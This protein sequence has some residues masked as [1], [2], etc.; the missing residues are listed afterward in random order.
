MEKTF[1]NFNILISSIRNIRMLLL[2]I[3]FLLFWI[4]QQSDAENAMSSFLNIDAD[5]RGTAMGGAYGALTSGVN[6]TYWNPAGLSEIL[7]REFGATYY[8]AFQ[9][10]NYSFIGYAVPSDFYGS[11]ACQIFYLGSGSIISTYENPDGS[12]IGAGDSF[13]VTDLAVGLTQSKAITEN[14]SYGVTAKII[15]HRIKDKNAFDLAG[16][17]GA[18]YQPPVYGL[19]LGLAIRNL[20]TMY[21]FMNSKTREPW[22]VKLSTAYEL[23]N[24]PLTI[25]SDYNI[26][27]GQKD[28]LSV[29]AEY[30][31][32][33][34]LAI[35]AGVKFPSTTG[36]ISTFN[37]GI[38]LNLLDLYQFDHAINFNS[39][40]GINQRFSLIVKF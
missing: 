38:G 2:V 4:C 36:F 34:L 18:I 16:D 29:G 7:F 22:N 10:I 30:W 21:R 25:A 19:K 11:L 26:I 1:L 5:A 24:I 35:R 33:D 37:C 39:A 40:L 32:F 28:S 23:T 12:F 8:R 9:D 3:L 6:S 14:F 27:R 31:I 15:T 20:S 13:S 17:A